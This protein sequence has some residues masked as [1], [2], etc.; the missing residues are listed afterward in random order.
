MPNYV[1]IKSKP[2][3]VKGCSN[4]RFSHGL[5]KFHMH[6]SRAEVKSI[7][8][9]SLKRV[10]KNKEYDK[11][12]RESDIKYSRDGETYCFFCLVPTGSVKDHHHVAGRTGNLLLK[13]IVPAHSDCHL[14]PNG[15]HGIAT[16]KLIHKPYFYR[17]MALVKETDEK[18]YNI[19]MGKIH[20]YFVNKLSRTENEWLGIIDIINS[21][22]HGKDS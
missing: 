10:G 11:A 17:Y 9:Y 22:D 1:R 2:C 18:K 21:F 16:S 13:G 4:P 8:Q 5:C 12:C 15:F 14:A 3:T 6:A 19:M 20:D 7:R